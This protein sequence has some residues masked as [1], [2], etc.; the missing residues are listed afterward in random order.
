MYLPPRRWCGCI[1]ALL[2]LQG[3]SY[4]PPELLDVDNICKS[5]EGVAD[6]STV[7]YVRAIRQQ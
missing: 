6:A 2:C 5:K 4:L 3:V 7:V 1:E